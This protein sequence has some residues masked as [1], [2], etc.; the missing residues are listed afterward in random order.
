MSKEPAIRKRPTPPSSA[1][2]PVA[3]SAAA[4][5]PLGQIAFLGQSHATAHAPGSEVFVQA[6]CWPLTSNAWTALTQS[7]STIRALR[8][9]SAPL[10]KIHKGPT[11]PPSWVYASV[12]TL[13][14]PFRDNPA[15]ESTLAAW[16]ARAQVSLSLAVIPTVERGKDTSPYAASM[17]ECLSGYLEFLRFPGYEPCRLVVAGALVP[18]DRQQLTSALGEAQKRYRETPSMQRLAKLPL[19]TC[20]DGQVP[21]PVDFASL[22]SAAV[23]RYVNSP[24]IP[25]PI[26]DAIRPKLVQVPR[27][28]A[29]L[30]SHRRR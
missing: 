21:L 12:A 7:W 10:I 28:I 22:V 25:N 6:L 5:I 3:T 9:S 26:F 23:A 20:V 11:P 1:A 4:P 14:A 19:K 27:R 18:A 2:A 30:E 16:M 13:G 24:A 17:A 8:D 15:E 29:A